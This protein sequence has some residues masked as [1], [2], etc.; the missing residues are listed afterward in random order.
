[1]DK[2]DLVIVPGV[3]FDEDLN[4]IGFGKGYYDRI[5]YRLSSRAKK[6]AVAH[7]FQVLNSIPSEEHD[8]KMDIIVTEKRVI[9]AT[10]Q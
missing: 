3:A 1:M 6:V 10:L 4:R 9:G 2:I 8:V 5:L 7:D